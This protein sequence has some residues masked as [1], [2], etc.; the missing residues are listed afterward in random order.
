MLGSMSIFSS[1]SLKVIVAV[2]SSFMEYHLLPLHNVCFTVVS[3]V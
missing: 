3:V 1:G 2:I